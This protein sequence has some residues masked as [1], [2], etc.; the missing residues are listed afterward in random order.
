MN[1]AKKQLIKNFISAIKTNIL[2]RKLKINLK[3]E[4]EL[5]NGCAMIPVYMDPAIIEAVYPTYPRWEKK[6]LKRK[7]GE[8]PAL[9]LDVWRPTRP[10]LFDF[11]P[12]CK[13]TGLTENYNMV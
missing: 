10:S 1:E 7:Y 5:L 13:N 4:K 11:I 2:L 12:R 3:D 6:L 9:Y 8:R